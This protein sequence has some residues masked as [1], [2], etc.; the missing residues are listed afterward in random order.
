MGEPQ[1]IAQTIAQKKATHTHTHTRIGLTQTILIQRPSTVW[2]WLS[3]WISETVHS[4]VQYCRNSIRYNCGSACKQLSTNND[5]LSIV[6]YSTL[7]RES[8]SQYRQILFVSL[9]KSQFPNDLI[10]L[11]W[12]RYYCQSSVCWMNCRISKI[13]SHYVACYV[14]YD[15]T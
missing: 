12:R 4:T 6:T 10:A 15:T 9:Y 8:V 11:V 14:M 5:E 7:V 1:T 2:L 13:T 3:N